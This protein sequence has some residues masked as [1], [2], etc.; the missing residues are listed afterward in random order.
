MVKVNKL[1]AFLDSSLPRATTKMKRMQQSLK[2][3]LCPLVKVFCVCFFFDKDGSREIQR[4]LDINLS[5]NKKA[6]SHLFKNVYFKI[7]RV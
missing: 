2:A 5:A 4:N 7:L 3:C 6:A 1:V